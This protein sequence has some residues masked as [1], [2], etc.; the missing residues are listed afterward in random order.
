MFNSDSKTALITGASRGI[1]KGIAKA[2]ASD[3]YNLI[4]ICKN[5]IGLLE[6]LSA[7]LTAAYGIKCVCL[8]ADVSQEDFISEIFSN[9]KRLDVLINN[10]GI[11]HIGL[12]QDMSLSEWQTIINTNLT[13]AFLTSRAAIPVMLKQK[14]GCIINISSMWGRVGASMEAAYSASKGGLNAL[15]MAL[16]KEL[17]PSGIQVNAIAPGVVDTDMNSH[18][19]EDE[20]SMLRE[21]IPADR[22]ASPEEVGKAVLSII[23][24]GSY[25]TGQIIGF[26]GGYV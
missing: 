22:F 20:L 4:L 5:N 25:L 18:L 14:Q 13:S 9:I 6:N 24:A 17:A 19:S 10:A 12:L 15:T 1:G 3:G 2:L 7:E 11:A 21:E 26:D 23:N 16:A 8:C